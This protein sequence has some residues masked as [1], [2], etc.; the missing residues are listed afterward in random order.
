MT[1][2]MQNSLAD[3]GDLTLSSADISSVPQVSSQQSL[4]EQHSPK[5]DTSFHESRDHGQFHSL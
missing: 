3:F 5:S 4:Q 1:G 2:K